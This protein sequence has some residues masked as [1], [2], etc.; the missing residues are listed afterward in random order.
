MAPINAVPSRLALPKLAARRSE[1][2]RR[3]L[4]RFAS[5]SRSREVGTM[6]VRSSELNAGEVG[7]GEVS[8]FTVRV[9]EVLAAEVHRE[10]MTTA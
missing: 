4:V 3:A 8:P 2:S 9:A 6:K 1:S 5:W 7:L 10:E